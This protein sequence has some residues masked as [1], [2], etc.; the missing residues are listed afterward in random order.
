MWLNLCRILSFASLFVVRAPVL[1]A[2]TTAWA[3]LTP[4]HS[5]PRAADLFDAMLD[6]EDNTIPSL[7]AVRTATLRS[8][9][10][11]DGN[12]DA[13][14]GDWDPALALAASHVAYGLFHEA[15][16]LRN[17]IGETCRNVSWL[18]GA[19]LIAT[20]SKAALGRLESDA[21]A[22]DRAAALWLILG[23]SIHQKVDL[24]RSRFGAATAHLEFLPK[25]L[26][27]AGRLHL[28]FA[29]LEAG[30]TTLAERL[31]EREIASDTVIVPLTGSFPPIA[32]K[33]LVF[34]ILAEKDGAIETAATQYESAIAGGG[35]PGI[36]AAL[37]LL[38][39]RWQGDPALLSQTIRA[40]EDL[41]WTWRGDPIERRILLTLIRAYSL[42]GH[43]LIAASLA[44]GMVDRF[45]HGDGNTQ[46]HEI[47]EDIISAKLNQP[48]RSTVEALLRFEVLARYARQ[49]LITDGASESIMQMLRM[50]SEQHHLP[51]E[52]LRPDTRGE[53]I[54][55]P[56]L[57]L[58]GQAAARPVGVEATA[59]QARTYEA[60]PE[61][62]VSPLL[63]ALTQAKGV[64]P[65][66][67]GL[68]DE[69]QQ[70]M[71]LLDPSVS[72]IDPTAA[73]S[74]FAYIDETLQA[75]ADLQTLVDTYLLTFL[76]DSGGQAE[77]ASQ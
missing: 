25:P 24:D 68:S 26:R 39:L 60:G 2:P 46:G 16:G 40:L 29:A 63:A 19:S 72:S 45:A 27:L 36:E 21:A 67:Y 23:A 56:M 71:S 42:G 18:L 52:V 17:E 33:S 51:I 75:S 65:A 9:S 35:R 30:Q 73:D 38:N 1:L 61:H 62:T 76:R 20:G 6:A 53:P 37:R 3:D 50:L 10:K 41:R 12:S 49:V 5:C 14:P 4:D 48:A 13:L 28:A 8:I 77:G 57:G 43:P 31:V 47:I 44:S 32:L 34:G 7:H 15:H 69:E 11:P 58:K 64:T 22:G 66:D 54:R 59:Y 55:L 70:M 74:P